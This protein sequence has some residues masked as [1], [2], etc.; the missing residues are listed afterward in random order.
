MNKLLMVATVP[1][2][3]RGFLLPIASHFR[4]QG[5]CVDAIACEISKSPECLQGFDHVWDVNWSRNP[6]DL[7]NL[8]LAPHMI[9]EIVQQRQYDIV[10]VH[11]P[12]AAFI[13][14]Y[15]LKN[16]RQHGKPLVIYTAH[17]FHFYSGGKLFKNTMFLGLE[18]LAGSWTNYL[19]VI[20][21]EDEKAAQQ[22][23]LIPPEYLQ[24]MP[25]IGV[26]LNYYSRD[27]ISKTA[28][29]QVRQELGLTPT[30]PLFL[31][32]G[33][34]IPRKHPQDVLR[35]FALL[36]GKEAFLAF[37]GHGPL[38]TQMQKLASQLGV[39]DQIHFLGMR[40]DIPTLMCAATTTV[41][42]S[43]QEGL[44]RC[45]MESMA[46][47]TPVIGTAIRGTQD[48]LAGGCGLLVKVGDIEGLAAAMTWVLDNPRA[49]K[50]MTQRAHERIADYDLSEILQQHETLYA[51]AMP[52]RS[53]IS[54][55]KT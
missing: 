37:A 53:L 20:N 41:L 6:F 16:L 49:V 35:A 17:G 32:V 12:V 55:S 19:V 9:Q 36:E 22:H 21:H 1:E 51:K 29:E 38:M 3:I 40:R 50:V 47:Q 54:T 46:M 4:N 11:T 18:K 42:A 44:P 33:E 23:R 31:S 39:Q 2:T 30:T 28:V 10:H 5:W 7:R 27:T 13:T 52:Y 48:L 24:F 34:L 14:R 26:D 25:G 8:L 45:V 43:E 15:A